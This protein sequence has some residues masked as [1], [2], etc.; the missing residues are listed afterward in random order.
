MSRYLSIPNGS[1]VYVA[2]MAF[3]D[4]QEDAIIMNKTSIERGLFTTTKI[5][6]KIININKGTQILVDGRIDSTVDVDENGVVREGQYIR[7]KD[8]L[9]AIVENCPT[10]EIKVERYESSNSD[11]HYV[12]KVIYTDNGICIITHYTNKVKVG[13]KFESKY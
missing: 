10:K 8:Y 5:Q 4:N 9:L 1:N 7:N 3:G 13:D 6:T 12:Y 2:I 11:I